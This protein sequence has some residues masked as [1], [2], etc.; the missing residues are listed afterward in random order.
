V[1]RCDSIAGREVVFGT[2]D[3]GA[4]QLWSAHD[5]TLRAV[6]EGCSSR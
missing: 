4:W 2:S 3:D 1:E 5:S 6:P